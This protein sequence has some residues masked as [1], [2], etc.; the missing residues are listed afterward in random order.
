MC[1]DYSEWDEYYREIP[2][3]ELGWELGKP[4][5]LLVEYV[6]TGLISKGNALDTCCGIGTN[7]IYLAQNGFEVTCVDIS[8]TAIEMA[9]KKTK[10]AKVKI[11]F[12]VESFIDLSF[13][14]EVFDFV[15]DMG[16]FHHVKTNDRT[17]FIM[18]I[19]RVMKKGASYL[20]TCFSSRNGPAWNHFTKLQIKELFSDYF[21]LSRIRHY[22]SLEGDGYVRFFY[23]VL[24]KKMI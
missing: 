5:P 21:E 2:I 16:C 7:P 22:P 1:A 13:K 18:G 8:L 6:E 14:D 19:H 12:F 15:F 23:T 17:K 24:M 10:Q 20:L 3:K 9:K 11:N 4:R